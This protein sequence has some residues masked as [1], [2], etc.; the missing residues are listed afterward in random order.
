MSSN[1]QTDLSGATTDLSGASTDVSGASTDVSGASMDLSGASMFPPA[2]YTVVDIPTII[3]YEAP[4]G[5]SPPEPEPLSIEDLLNNNSVIV[6]KEN[7]DRA[8]LERFINPTIDEVKP[9]LLEWARAGLPALY[10]IRHVDVSPPT[11][12]SDGQTRS[13]LLYYE[14][15]M[16]KSLSDTLGPLL[17]KTKGMFFSFSHNGTS[18]ISLHVSKA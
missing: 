5:P 6:R 2:N 10:A 3:P 14:Y 15:L 9:M 11:V 13:L 18:T 12:C 7:D 8:T 16:G 4:I 1:E 17:T